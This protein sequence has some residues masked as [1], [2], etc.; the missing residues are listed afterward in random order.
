MAS[1]GAFSFA[2]SYKSPGKH[3]FAGLTKSAPSNPVKALKE[4]LCVFAGNICQ[5]L[6]IQ[7]C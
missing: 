7:L 2:H 5:Y 1:P 3:V 4:L 6:Q